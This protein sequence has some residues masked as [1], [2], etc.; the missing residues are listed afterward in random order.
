MKTLI[1]AILAA[2]LLFVPNVH[3]FAADVV[4]FDSTIRLLQEQ[5]TLQLERI[6]VA[7]EKADNQMSLARIRIDE[8]LR[9][10]GEDLAVQIEALERL[11]EQLGEKTRQTEQNISLWKEESA[12]LFSG[13]LTDIAS[14]INQTNELIGRLNTIR[15]QVGPD[16][17]G[18]QSTN[19]TTTGGAIPNTL[20]FD[21]STLP[22]N[23]FP[24]AYLPS[25]EPPV[26]PSVAP[27]GG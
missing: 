1:A 25:V 18:N 11:R 15:N 17:P 3:T 8:Q 23:A 10:S 4:G 16:C 21:P 2:F 20:N 6:R 19:S 12:H 9:R 22:S 5:I 13:A 26:F 7:R 24:V 14:Q 27:S